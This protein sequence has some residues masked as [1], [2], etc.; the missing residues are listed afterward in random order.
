[1][2][3]GV[4][5]SPLQTWLISVQQRGR[6]M[7]NVENKDRE[8]KKGEKKGKRERET[9]REEKIKEK[10]ISGHVPRQATLN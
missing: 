10:S 4:R 6:V 7:A 8:G 2:R 1:M 9:R 3:G 5:N